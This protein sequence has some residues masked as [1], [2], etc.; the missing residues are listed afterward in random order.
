MSLETLAPVIPPF[1]DEPSPT[2]TV[3]S[4]NYSDPNSPALDK[5][6]DEAGG[7]VVVASRLL[8]DR[9]ISGEIQ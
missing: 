9:M 8:L 3:I 2:K 6:L 4:E 5:L 7:R 1:E